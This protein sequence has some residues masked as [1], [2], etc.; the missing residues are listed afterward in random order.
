MYHRQVFFEIQSELSGFKTK[1]APQ[2]VRPL[3]LPGER[4]EF[5]TSKMS[6]LLG[7]RHPH[8]IC[9]EFFLYSLAF[10]NVPTNTDQAGDLVILITEGNLGVSNQ[11][12]L[13]LLINHI[14][15]PIDH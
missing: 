7:L 1:D 8:F 6:N 11:V 10:G 3:H 5:P 2:F 4:V 13:A 12:F 9:L 15:F 14:L